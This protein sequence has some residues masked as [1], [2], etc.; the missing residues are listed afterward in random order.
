MNLGT[1]ALLVA[2]LAGAWLAWRRGG[3]AIAVGCAAAAV[4]PLM[5]LVQ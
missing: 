3:R 5:K 1:L 4:L 2:L